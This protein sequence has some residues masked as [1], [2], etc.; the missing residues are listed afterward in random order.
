MSVEAIAAYL[1]EAND[2]VQVSAAICHLMS[3]KLGVIGCSVSLH[4]PSGQPVLAVD[5]LSDS[6]DQDQL[7]WLLEGWKQDPAFGSLGMLPSEMREEAHAVTLPLIHPGGLLGQI[8]CTH[9]EIVSPWLRRDMS[10]LSTSASVRLTQLG[11]T[12]TPAVFK[13]LTARQRDVARLAAKG[14]TNAEIA[15]SLGCSDNTVKKHLKDAFGLLGVSNRTGLA[16]V[17][18]RAGPIHDYPFGVSRLGEV[19]VVCAAI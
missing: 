17:V 14:L 6:A 19:R 4:L 5:N 13:K 16:G 12:A 10:T 9:R 7:T 1:A 15:K 11:V 18:G 3:T 8:R 2:F